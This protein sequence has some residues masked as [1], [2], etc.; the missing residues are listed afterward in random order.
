MKTDKWDKYTRNQKVD[1]I[2]KKCKAFRYIQFDGYYRG[3][4]YF[5]HRQIDNIAIDLGVIKCE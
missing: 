2:I 3:E 1:L 4:G 5:T